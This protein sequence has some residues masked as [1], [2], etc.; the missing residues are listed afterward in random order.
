MLPG[1]QSD[2]V[3]LAEDSDSGNEKARR[4]DVRRDDEWGDF[5]RIEPVGDTAF[6]AGQTRLVCEGAHY[7]KDGDSINAFEEVEASP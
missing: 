7:L 5:V 4:V 6:V 3:F 1:D 2:Y